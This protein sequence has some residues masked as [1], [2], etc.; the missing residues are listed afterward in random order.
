[1]SE[2]SVARIVYRVWLTGFIGA[3]LL[4]QGVAPELRGAGVGLESWIDRMDFA[5]AWLTQMVGVTGALL[6]VGLLMDALRDSPRRPASGLFASLGLLPTIVTLVAAEGPVLEPLVELSLVSTVVLGGLVSLG[7]ALVSPRAAIVPTA[8]VVSLG[9]RLILS[10]DSDGGAGS[11][12]LGILGISA[13]AL[14]FCLLAWKVLLPTLSKAVP[15]AISS[16]SAPASKSIHIGAIPFSL[17]HVI[18]PTWVSLVPHGIATLTLF[19]AALPLAMY[20]VWTSKRAHDGFTE[21]AM[22]VACVAPV[23][24]LTT[25]ALVL[26][27]L[28]MHLGEW[29]PKSNAVLGI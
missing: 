3:L 12:A 26:C 19:G 20:L 1:M 22:L 4:A 5:S 14:V 11:V 23:S 28:L 29:R 10:F 16:R 24:P 27:F 6:I 17:T 7:R 9:C 8:A 2:T 15:T 25:A 18:D 21:G 13:S